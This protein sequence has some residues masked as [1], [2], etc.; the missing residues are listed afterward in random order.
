[1]DELSEVMQLIDR[2]SDKLPEGD[3]LEICN[4]LKKVYSKR[5]D[6][7]FFFDYENFEIPMIGPTGEVHDYF[8]E[9][10]MNQAISLDMDYITGEIEYLQKELTQLQ[11][12]RRKTKNLKDVVVKHH[13][14][15]NDLVPEEQTL[16]TL[17]LNAEDV[18]SMTRSFMYMENTFREKYRNAIEKRL[19]NLEGALEKLYET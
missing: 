18:D 1:M 4:R 12:L 8:Y 15:S 13:C 5:N 6:P 17:G 11:P 10:Y 2:N 16:E 9:H 7:T 14:L 19:N 3:Y